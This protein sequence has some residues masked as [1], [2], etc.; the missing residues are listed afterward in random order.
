MGVIISGLGFLLVLAL[1]V[2]AGMGLISILTTRFGSWGKSYHRLA[3]RAVIFDGE[4][5]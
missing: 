3:R 4:D 1:I 5:V 2:F